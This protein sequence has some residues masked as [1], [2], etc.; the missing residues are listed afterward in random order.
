M[1]LPKIA[2]YFVGR[3]DGYEDCMEQLLQI[4]KD[5]DP[6]FFMS[7][8]SESRIRIFELDYLHKFT[9]ILIIKE[10]QIV[11]KKTVL[12]EYL[13][14]EYFA[15]RE[16]FFTWDEEKKVASFSKEK[17]MNRKMRFFKFNGTN[18]YNTYSQLYHTKLVTQHILNY[19]KENSMKFDV[20]LK[21]RADIKYTEPLIL[22]MPLDNTI[23][24]PEGRDH[25]G[26]INDTVAYGNVESMIEYS[27]TVDNIEFMLFKNILYHPESLLK[28]H[29]TNI[30]KIN[31][32]RFPFKTNLT[33]KRRLITISTS[34]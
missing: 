16:E 8:N 9:H 19:Q 1:A 11:I 18:I 3:I 4:K 15:E 26:G 12:P 13:N 6:T 29:L 21:F 10:E 28:F 23:Y 14:E 27:K 32:V 31:I 25:D 24:I 5:Y 30:L 2:V 33:D 20:I 34:D 22:T 7:L 17:F